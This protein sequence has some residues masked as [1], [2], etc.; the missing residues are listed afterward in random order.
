MSRRQY[1][2]PDM[3]QPEGRAGLTAR[4]AKQETA[5]WEEIEAAC[6]ELGVTFEQAVGA[7]LTPVV[8]GEE[9]GMRCVEGCGRKVR[10]PGRCF[11]CRARSMQ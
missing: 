9:R 2:G 5:G 11:E 3:T 10:R 4:L 7:A 6:D 1:E 8:D